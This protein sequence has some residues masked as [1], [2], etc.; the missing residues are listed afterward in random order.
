MIE[1]GLYRRDR[2]GLYLAVEGCTGAEGALC[3]NGS[4]FVITLKDL[5]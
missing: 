3:W 1:L 4:L 5:G 2:R